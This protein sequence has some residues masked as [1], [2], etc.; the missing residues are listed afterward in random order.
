MQ[1]GAA[2]F[3]FRQQTYSNYFEMA[4]SLALTYVEMPLYWQIIQ[5]SVA[6]GASKPSLAVFEQLR[7]QAEQAGVR[8]IAGVS[9]LEL[10]GDYNM[11]GERIDASECRFAKA[12]AYRTLDITVQLGLEVVRLTEPNVPPDFTQQESRAYMDTYGFVLRELGDYAADHGI[13][14]VVENYG[15][16]STQMNWLLDAADHPAVGTLYDPC[17]YFRIGE[18]P[19]TALHNL[20]QRVYY[21]HMKDTRRD[22]VRPP[23]ILFKGSRWAPSVAVGEG[24]IDWKPILAKLKTFY[25][26]YLCVEYEMAED[27]MRGTRSSI[28]HIKNI[29]QEAM[30]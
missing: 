11:R 29:L 30:C 9:A 24:D 26:G 10:A 13:Q 17:N 21:C 15:M 3:G 27:V 8:M 4:A 6:D 22:E 2:W 12:C 23:D 20:G 5:E 16:T 25:S 14:I 18:D 28:S 7:Q 19:L 1:L